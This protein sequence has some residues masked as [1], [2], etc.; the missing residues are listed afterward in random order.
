LDD[1]QVQQGLRNELFE[2]WLNEKI[3]KLKVQLK[4]PE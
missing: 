2:R 3:Q 4:V 1:A